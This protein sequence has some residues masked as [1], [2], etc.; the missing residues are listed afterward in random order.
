MPYKINKD[1]P[2]SIKNNLPFHAQ[3]IYRKTFNN[4]Y[5]QYPEGLAHQTAWAAVKKSY[6]KKNDKWVKK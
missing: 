1:L 4:A 2:D 6:K 5:K 3:T